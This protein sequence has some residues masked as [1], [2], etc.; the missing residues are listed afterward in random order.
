[1]KSNNKIALALNAIAKFIIGGI[2][3][4]ALLFIPAGSWGYVGAW[5]LLSLLF[6]PMFLMGVYMLFKSPEL[7]KRRLS[8]K[9]KRSTQKGVMGLSGLIISVG[10]IVSGLDWRFGWSNVGTT[11]VMVGSTLFLIGYGLYFEVLRENV[12]VSRTIEVAQGQ[13]VVQTGLYGI[14]R[15]PM[16]FAA[17]LM[18]VPI[19]LVLGSWWALCAFVLYVPLLMVRILDEERMLRAELVGYAEYCQKV[20][21]RI[22]PF[23]W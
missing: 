15:H 13:K 22:L 6:G 19:P 3:Y 9:E 16:Y 21:W 1:M 7:L 11:A 23:V 17:L 4:A 10:F 12:W 14:V 2:G 5:R 20:K 8:S 18:F